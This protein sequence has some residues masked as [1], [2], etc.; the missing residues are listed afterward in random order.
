MR[1]ALHDVE[2]YQRRALWL[3]VAAFPVPQRGNGKAKPGRELLLCEAETAPQRLDVRR[4]Q[5]VKPRCDGFA[6]G[7]TNG[8][9]SPWR[10]LSTALLTAPLPPCL[11]ADS[12]AQPECVQRRY[13][14]LQGRIALA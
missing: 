7:V 3:A 12:Q 4:G 2:Q 13:Q 6:L 9:V 10:T 11:H 14:G 1:L 5:G 8:L